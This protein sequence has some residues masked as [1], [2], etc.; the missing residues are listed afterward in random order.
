MP[1]SICRPNLDRAL[2]CRQAFYQRE[3][4]DRVLACFSVGC[5]PRVS[6]LRYLPDIHRMCEVQIDYLEAQQ[7]LDDDTVPVVQT[8][9]GMGIFG[10]M[11]GSEVVW[12]PE[13]DT[14]WSEPPF[15]TWPEDYRERLR[16]DPRHPLVEL[17]Q[18]YMR[19]CRKRANGRFGIGLLETIDALNLVNELRGGTRGF[20][21]LYLHPDIVSEV[22]DLG[23]QWN[24][25]WLEMQMAESGPFAGGWVS[26]VDWFPSPTVWLSVDAYGACRLETYVK[27]GRTYMQR[28]IDHFGHGWQHLHS[29]GVRLL[30]E[31][32]KLR[33]LV[34]IQIGED[35][36]Y[37]R[38]FEIVREIQA[39]TGD[40]PLQI[41]CRWREFRKALERGTLAGGVEYHVR[42]AP[43]VNA[44]N[45]LAERVRAYRDDHRGAP[46]P[47]AASP[48]AEQARD[49]PEPRIR[50]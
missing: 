40:I 9:L 1:G 10:A 34:G 45:R 19:H 33:N 25:D 39:T 27:M 11:F 17:A 4:R 49:D 48:G 35:V 46:C 44:A 31:I 37:P 6:H 13:D 50:R 24:I 32:V 41:G 14:S 47:L 42:G 15:E 8:H 29:D 38:P 2:A 20:M 28:L 21:D 18:R 30:P 23:I 16:F 3:M 22:M 36:G 7:A 5:M 12:R 43:S 26:L